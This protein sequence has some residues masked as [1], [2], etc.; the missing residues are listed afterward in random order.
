MGFSEFL[1]EY[2]RR[3]GDYPGS[4]VVRRLFQMSPQVREGELECLLETGYLWDD[5]KWDDGL[6]DC[7]AKPAKWGPQAT[8]V[9]Y[10]AVWRACDVCDCRCRFNWRCGRD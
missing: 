1:E 4:E 3:Y 8:D 6:G 9:D 2:R 7:P 10:E 5:I